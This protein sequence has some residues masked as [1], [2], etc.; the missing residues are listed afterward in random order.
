[1]STS[2]PCTFEGKPIRL[3]V[4]AVPLQLSSSYLC[5]WQI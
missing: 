2:S 1:M 4:H 3:L 5:R